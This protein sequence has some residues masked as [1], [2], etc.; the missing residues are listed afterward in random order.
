M[1]GGEVLVKTLRKYGVKHVFGLPG[2]HT[3]PIYEAIYDMQPEMRHILVR[4]EK[5]GALM[6]DGYARVAYKVGVCDAT[7]GPGATNL[8]SGIAEAHYSSIPVVAITGNVHSAWVGKGALQEC[9]H[10]SLFRPITK[11]SVRIDRASRVPEFVREA[12][13][14]ATTEKPGPVH[15][16]LPVD[17]LTGETDAKIYAESQCAVYPA[18]R[19]KPDPVK[20]VRAAELMIEMERPVIVAG[21]GVIISQA[22]SEVMELAETLSIPVATTITGKGAIPEDHPLSIGVVGGIGRASAVKVVEQADVVL[23]IGCKTGQIATANW[24][25]PKRDSKIIHIDIDPKVIG[26]N[27]PVDVRIVGDAKATIK[28]LIDALKKLI[29]KKPMEEMPWISM[30]R[31][32]VK[33]WRNAVAPLL[34]SDDI[35]IKP[36]RVMK[37]L[38]N[39]LPKD[40]ILVCDASLSTAWGSVYFDV[41]APGRTFIAPRGLAGIG[42]GFPMALGAKLAAPSKKVVCIT[43]DGGFGMESP[44]LET[45]KREKIPLVVVVLNNKC[46]GWIKLEQKL[47]YKGKF[48]SSDFLDLN[49]GKIAEAYGCHGSRT[50]R[51]GEIKEALEKAVKVEEPAV[52]DVIIDPWAEPPLA[53]Q[54]Y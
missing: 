14:R 28:D 47:N 53:V 32:A 19:V 49:F 45:A 8:V 48:L 46:L 18:Y 5:C 40:A 41:L 23:L 17:V 44:E 1:K 12:F 21:G 2:G 16:D 26:K 30:V 36:Q 20:I 29:R 42:S 54:L 43:G 4:D 27:F 37:E 35:P 31:K 13:R 51:P 6:A 38:R 52:I 22:W 15:L 34:S 39:V 50:E 9:D 25:L 10:L 33:E 24:S 7:V 11:W 3:L